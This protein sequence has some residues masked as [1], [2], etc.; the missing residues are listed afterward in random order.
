MSNRCKTI[1]FFS[2]KGGAGRSSTALNTLPFLVKE[3]NADAKHPI[4]LLDMDLDSAGMTY[5][6][7]CDK[8]FQK[9]YDVKKF[10]LN[11]EKCSSEQTDDLAHHPLLKHF[12]PVGELLGVEREA[13]LFL[14]DNDELPIDNDQMDGKKDELFKKLRTFCK[15]NSIPAYVMDSAAGDQFS[16]ILA[17]ENSKAVVCCMRPT[18]QFRIG[19]FNYLNRL[20]KNSFESE[21]ILLPTVVPE[22]DLML[23]G[24]M[25]KERAISN[26]L[27][28][29]SKINDT[30]SIHTDFVCHENFGIN[31][32]HR[33]KWQEGVLYLIAQNQD[34]SSDEKTAYERYG[35]L[36]A[37]LKDIGD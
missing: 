8:F 17:T 22:N 37:L 3:L 19:T 36:A 20:A 35:R 10:L 6:L 2:Y 14:G 27:Y 12:L 21:I 4:L 25:Q 23:D 9:N 32:V 18:M 16:A 15:N 11:E 7:G 24:E 30:L 29:T 28:R 26:I 34:L 1:T 5:L 33:F 13:V 31:E